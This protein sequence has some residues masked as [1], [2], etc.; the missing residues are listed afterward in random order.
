MLLMKVLSEIHRAERGL[1]E[2]IFIEDHSN[3]FLI[4]MSLW[5]CQGFPNFLSL[6]TWIITR[7]TH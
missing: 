3:Q 4:K 7:S 1:F 6:F 5:D 2:K